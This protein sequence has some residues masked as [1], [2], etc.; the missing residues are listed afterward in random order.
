MIDKKAVIC[1]VSATIFL[2][3]SG[4]FNDSVNTY[5]NE[6]K[7][8]VP[9]VVMDKRVVTD[10]FLKRRLVFQQ[11]RQSQTNDGFKRIQVFMKSGRDGIFDSDSPHKVVYRFDWFDKNGV[12]VTGI[13]DPGWQKKLILPGDDIS[14]T[15]VAPNQ[16]CVDFKI[17]IKEAN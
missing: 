17:R 12:K 5:E 16:N 7:E 11:I 9:D 15:S 10:N 14:F 2:I 8:G 6:K 3:L 13:D 1:G 4:C